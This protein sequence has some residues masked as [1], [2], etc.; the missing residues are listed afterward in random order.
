MAAALNSQQ[1]LDA[2]VQP[3]V[4][5]MDVVNRWNS[6]LHMLERL[7][8]LSIAIRYLMDEIRNST[9]EKRY[10]TKLKECMLSSSEWDDVEDMVKVLSPIENLTLVFSAASNGLAASIYPWFVVVQEELS[11]ITVRSAEV[12]AFRLNLN[13]DLNARHFKPNMSILLHS[14]IPNKR[15]IFLPWTNKHRTAQH[16]TA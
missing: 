7:R 15:E 10:A 2:S 6:T 13:E 14:S 8:K 4:V 12:N 9:E 3:V 1:Q 5:I 11:Y 16:F